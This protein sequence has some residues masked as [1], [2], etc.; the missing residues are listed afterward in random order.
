M[1]QVWKVFRADV[2]RLTN[3]VV[4][5]VIIMGL[6][7]I[8][9]LYAWFNIL[10]NWDPYGESATSAMHVAVFSED[11]GFAYG[12]VGLN[13]GDRVIEGLGA[14]K[15]IGWVFPKTKKETLEMVSSGECYAALII[16]KTFS[17]DMLSFLGGDPY[18]PKIEYYENSKKNAIATKIT[19]KAKNA[20]QQQV[21]ASFV[22]TLAEGISSSGEI[23]T[24]DSPTG[25][26]LLTGVVGRMEVVDQNLLT[27]ISIL[28]TLALVTDSTAG[29][30]DSTQN[31]IPNFSSMLAAGQNSMANLQTTMLSGTQ[32]IDTVA[33]MVDIS[34]ESVINGLEQFQTQMDNISII[35]DNV[36]ITG[37][38]KGTVNL[39][40]QIVSVL[41]GLGA[42]STG[43][44]KAKLEELQADLD[45]FSADMEKTQEKIDTFKTTVTEEITA[46]TTSLHALKTEFDTTIKPNLSQSMYQIQ[47]SLI[48]AQLML[49]NLDGSFDGTNEALTG[50][51]NT[52]N[53]GTD[54]IS[55][56]SEY[57]T[58]LEEQ[59]HS[60][61]V[62]LTDLANDKQYQEIASLFQTN[63]ELVATFITSPVSLE[64][65]DLYEIDNYGS[66]MA[67]FYTILGI[68]VGA[69]ILVALVHVK[70]E[71]EPETKNASFAAKFFG[72][73]LFFLCVGQAQTLITVLGDL[74]FVEIDCKHPFLFWLG[75][76]ISSLMFTSLMYSLTVAFGNVGEAIAVVLMV[77]QVAGAGCTFP[78]E[79]LPK[80]FQVI[81]PV[82]PFTFS[83]NALRECVG[84]LY[85][86][87]FFIDILVLLLMTAICFGIGL[88]LTKPFEKLNELIEKSKEKSGIM[89]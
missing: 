16:P 58:H 50:Y 73:Y 52:L 76:A 32:T 33:T 80:V 13:V 44:V 61:I 22:S 77:I 65:E 14:N 45:E 39:A 64:T 38:I 49:Q 75:A 74:F 11:E 56:T 34:L 54:S 89:L 26:P 28:N 66:A 57:V 88:G 18:H 81:A 82:L 10:S 67:P 30:V 21:N 68:W 78:V 46:C 36:D 72:R 60:V 6:S 51:Y 86:F 63:P 24:G 12:K 87:N 8:P 71:E 2:R 27:Y 84:G 41:D 17:E 5:L 62:S 1:K 35:I 85:R 59:L 47:Y 4:A 43:E 20:V 23:I 25:E 7:I 42:A 79:V 55:K 37:Q 3:N 83:M 48:Q 40:D 53:E 70:V 29:L 19:G 69:L 31:L 15:T 9:A